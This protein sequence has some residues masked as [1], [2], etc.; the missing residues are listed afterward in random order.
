I[1]AERR[2]T[3]YAVTKAG[4]MNNSIILDKLDEFSF[5]SLLYF[6]EVAT[7]A[8]GELLGIDAF[9]QPG[10]EEGKKATFALMGR[11]GYEEKAAELNAA[12]SGS[13]WICRV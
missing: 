9:D 10:V 6:F 13:D 1:E 4:K 7:A 5:G 8:A 11:A 2:A 12:A 3:V